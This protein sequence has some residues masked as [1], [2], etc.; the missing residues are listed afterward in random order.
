MIARRFES[1]SGLNE[2]IDGCNPKN[3]SRSIA[4]SA[5]PD[6][7]FRYGNRRTRSVVTG[8]T[9]RHDHVQSINRATLKNRNQRLSSCRPRL[10]LPIT[11]RSRNA[12]AESD[13]PMLAKAMLPDL[14]KNLR[15]II[16]ASETPAFPKSIPQLSS[17]D[18]TGPTAS[19]TFPSSSPKSLLPGSFSTTHPSLSP[20]SYRRS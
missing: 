9:K 7:R 18:P 1:Q 19:T 20:G 8:F 4:A 3:P 13:M 5:L 10:V 16:T 12:G 2:L 14:R 15:F 11:T 17:P 6:S